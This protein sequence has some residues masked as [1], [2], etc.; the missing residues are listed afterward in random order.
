MKK[1]CLDCGEPLAGRA[2]KKFCDDACRSNYNNRRN[3]EE[4]G[5]LRRVNSILKR[6][7]KI[8]ETLNPEG[9]VKVRWKTLV[10]AGFNFDY[11]TDMYETNNG[12]QYRFCY[13]YGYLLLD[14]DEVLLVKR[15]N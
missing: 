15:K 7:R 12:S 1:K 2:D 4:N 9:K 11:I 13:E 3:A 8:L 10:S 5:Y 6:N 14:N